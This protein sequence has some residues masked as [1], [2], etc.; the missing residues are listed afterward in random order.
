MKGKLGVH[1]FFKRIE[2]ISEN[3]GFKEMTANQAI[4]CGG[5]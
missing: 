4:A 5:K 3:L 1:D 2:R